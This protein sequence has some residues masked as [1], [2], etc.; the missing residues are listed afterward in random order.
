MFGFTMRSYESVL[1]R[2]RVLE[3]VWKCPRYEKCPRRIY[4]PLLIRPE[5]G[6][7]ELWQF[8]FIRDWQEIRKSEIPPSEFFPISADW[9]ELGI[10][11]LA[12][13]SLIKCYWMLQ[14]ARVTAFTVLSFTVPDYND[15]TISLEVKFLV[16]IKYISFVQHGCSFDAYFKRK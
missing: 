2:I 9:N 5:S 10:P 6:V 11:K 13:M 8:C 3:I 12:R 4:L 16:A 1:D 7:L 14:N 15:F